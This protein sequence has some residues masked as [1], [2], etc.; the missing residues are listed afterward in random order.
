MKWKMESDIMKKNTVITISALAVSIGLIL[1][2]CQAVVVIPNITNENIYSMGG[3][4]SPLGD[5]YETQSSSGNLIYG[6]AFYNNSVINA[7]DDNPGGNYWDNGYPSG[8]NYWDDWNGTDWY[9]G[10]NQ[11]ILGSDGIGDTIYT[12]GNVVDDYP[13]YSGDYQGGPEEEEELEDPLP[14]PYLKPTITTNGSSYIEETTATLLGYI[15]SDGGLYCTADFEYGTTSG[16]GSNTADQI[17]K[18]TG[19]SFTQGMSSLSPGTLYHFRA[20][21]SNDEG[22]GYGSDKTFLTKPYEPT[23]LTAS[24]YDESQV[25]LTWSTGI[26]ADRTVVERNTASSWN[27][28]EG[29][30]VVNGTGTTGTDTIEFING[31]KYYYQAWSYV[32][33]SSLFRFSDIYSSANETIAISLEVITNTTIGVEERN[34]TLK[35][36]LN[37]TGGVNV[38]VRFEYG[39]STGYGN[40]T[41]NQTKTQGNEFSDN[42]VG[43]ETYVIYMFTAYSRDDAWETNPE[44]MADGSILTY[45]TTTTVGDSELLIAN[46]CTG[47]Y[48]GN[49]SKVWIRLYGGTDA[50][51]IEN[52][53]LSFVPYFSDV[54]GDSYN[55][56][57]PGSLQWSSWYNITEDSSAP[58]NWTWKD[59]MNLDVNVTRAGTYA[60]DNVWCGQVQI[61]VNYTEGMLLPGTYYHVRA[62]SNKSIVTDYGNDITFL[63][64]PIQPLI[65]GSK[66]FSPNQINLTWNKGEGANNTH[67]ERNTTKDWPLGDA[68]CVYNGTGNHYENSGLPGGQVYYYQAW[69]YSEW[70]TFYHYS[71]FYT[72]NTTVVPP[73]I[74]TDN[75]TNVEETSATF[76][77][78]LVNDGGEP[79]T[80]WFEYGEGPAFGN[81]TS[82]ILTSAGNVEIGV[83]GLKEGTFYYFRGVANNTIGDTSDYGST[84]NFITKPITPTNLAVTTYNTTQL[85]LTWTRGTGAYKTYIERNTTSS[86]NLGNGTIVYNGTDSQYEDDVGDTDTLYYYQAWSYAEKVSLP[87]FNQY[88][89]IYDSGS[90]IVRPNVAV[91]TSS[92]V[93][94]I[95]ATLHGYLIDDGGSGEICTA[96][97]EYGTTLAYGSYT[98][99]SSVTT[100]DTFSGNATGLSAGT[101]YYI[102]AKANNSQGERLS[103]SNQ[104]LTKP[105]S[106]NGFTLTKI[107]QT[108][109]NLTW[110]NGV[111]GDGTY[112]RYTGAINDLVNRTNQTFTFTGFDA[113]RHD[114]ETNP[115][116]MI[117]KNLTTYASTSISDKQW[118]INNSCDGTKLGTINTVELRLYGFRTGSGNSIA[119]QPIF[120]GTRSTPGNAHSISLSTSPGWS[121]FVGITSDTNAPSIWN[122]TDIVNLDCDVLTSISSGSFNASKVDIKVSYT[123]EHTDQ[124]LVDVDGYVNNTWFEHTGLTPGYTYYYKVWAVAKDGGLTSNGTE[125]APFGAP[126]IDNLLIS[127]PSSIITNCTTGIEETNVTV[128]G[129]LQNDGGLNCS[130]W[131]EW[132]KTTSYGNKT[133]NETNK[134]TGTKFN[135]NISGFDNGTFY[136]Y[137]AVSNNSKATSY[138]YH[139]GFITK[140]LSPTSL[141]TT[142]YK[143]P[144]TAG[145]IN[146]TW[147]KG[148]GANRTIIR[149][150]TSGYPITLSDGR[151]LYN[152]TASFYNHT[153]LSQNTTYYYSAWSYAVWSYRPYVLLHTIYEFSDEY[154]SAQNITQGDIHFISI[155]GKGNSS[156]VD[157]DT[158][159]FIWNKTVNASMYW[160][161]IATDSNF[162][163]IT[164]NLMNISKYNFPSHCS[165]TAD[166]IIFTLPDT[167]SIAFNKIY[168][169]RVSAF[170]KGTT[171]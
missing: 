95:N 65:L 151:L 60:S 53:N 46:N 105:N 126:V 108:I 34:A 96:G 44:R 143:T 64:K 170:I 168:Y 31:Q 10:I 158:P 128:N 88:S 35:G 136:Y 125:D 63:T 92:G 79:C 148:N 165:E 42:T 71:D 59:I 14:S 69:G 140:P 68:I 147:V 156:Y 72:L 19:D 163:N 119:L 17:E 142:G 84:R 123:W 153:D 37:N 155:D 2:M 23:T 162:Y 7:Y 22:Y 145:A 4:I 137:R 86:W 28:G 11:N 26:G 78:T 154:G 114:W 48:L 83:S 33:H 106:I 29:V 1:T 118:L 6:N 70:G 73:T 36:Y 76:H 47:N 111:A 89:D 98:E 109:I 81:T 61:M 169:T 12:S 112:I 117:D 66:R 144:Y 146:L 134:T 97:L 157:S 102:R 100:G 32:S 82:S 24:I 18:I 5:G 55:W 141:T 138:G 38:F 45:A 57:K 103:S 3:D 160:L 150:S 75:P 67:I 49:I 159:T 39:T 90:N 171:W 135:K 116:N 124:L 94:I 20:R 139:K 132:G 107:N 91:N 122:W 164:L 41:V 56:I 130:L 85:N 58:E 74:Y 52:V 51:G 131:F 127:G 133:V 101:R 8:G 30:V 110:S 13:L 21:A 43:A 152:G 27:I 16:Y 99:N 121:S 93:E 120:N 80:V 15:A 166:S 129:Y 54:L 167:Y 161:E 104:I 9:S 40:I 77:A 50:P 25:N 149:Y 113:G 87:W 115:V 62:L